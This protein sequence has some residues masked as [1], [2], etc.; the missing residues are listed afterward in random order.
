MLN[1][2]SRVSLSLE[3]RQFEAVRAKEGGGKTAE[4]VLVRPG[5]MAPPVA[6]AGPYGYDELTLRI[7]LRHGIDSGTVQFFQDRIGRRATIVDQPRDERGN[8][9]FHTPY[10]SSGLV[11]GATPSDYDADGTDPRVLEVT[12]QPDTAT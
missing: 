12:V 10:T 11:T 8:A 2:Q 1:H 7:F 6:M 3:D 5:G 4:G 9:G